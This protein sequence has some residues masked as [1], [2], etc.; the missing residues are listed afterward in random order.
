MTENIRS[1]PVGTRGGCGEGW[2]PCACPGGNTICQGFREAAWS[3]SDEDKHKAPSSTPPRPLSLQKTTPSGRQNLSFLLNTGHI[4]LI[5]RDNFFCRDSGAL[6]FPYSVVKIYQDAG[7]FHYPNRSSKFISTQ[8][9]TLPYSVVKIRQ[10][11]VNLWYNQNTS[12]IKPL[13]NMS[14][15]SHYCI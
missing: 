14:G 3:H 7:S 4:P 8:A 10:D 11:G 1:R 13:F 5:L 2:G 6:P 15:Y 12:K 9:R